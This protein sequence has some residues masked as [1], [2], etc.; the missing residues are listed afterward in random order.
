MAAQPSFVQQFYAVLRT[1]L[2]RLI[3]C[4]PFHLVTHRSQSGRSR[5]KWRSPLSSGH[6]D[7]PGHRHSRYSLLYPFLRYAQSVK[8]RDRR[9]Q[10]PAIA[11]FVLPTVTLMLIVV[12]L[13]VA[14]LVFRAYNHT[15][16]I[17]GETQ[18][19]VIYNAA[20]PA[21]DRARAK[22][23]TLFDTNRDNRYP[24]GVPAENYL[25]GMLR[26]D[27]SYNVTVLPG[28]PGNDLYTLPGET[29]V[30]LDGQTKA[31]EARG[32]DNAWA[33][34][35][36]VN[37][38]GT[39]DATVVYAIIMQTPP[40]ATVASPGG[41]PNRSIPGSGIVSTSDRTKAQNLWV[42]TAPLS[43]RQR[44][45]CG[46]IDTQTAS[47]GQGWF[48]DLGNSSTL[49]KNFQIEALVI[50]DT[51]TTRPSFVTLEM[52]HDR[53]LDRGNKWGAWFRNDL[54]VFPGA[55]FNWNGA[56]H[57]EGNL[58]IQPGGGGSFTAFLVSAQ[59]SCLMSTPG[60]SEI[61]VTNI[62]NP[63]ADPTRTPDFIGGVLSGTVGSNSYGGSS[64]IHVWPALATGPSQ[65][66]ALN[67][68]SQSANSS[69]NPA[70]MAL[71]PV[72]L[73]TRD[74]SL[75]RNGDPSNR[76]NVAPNW[77][78]LPGNSRN[79]RIINRAEPKPYVDDLYRADD[80][81]GPKP[82][83][84]DQIV[85]R[86]AGQQPGTLITS[87]NVSTSED[88]ATLVNN[89]P[90]TD[91][92]ANVGLDGYWERRALNE[93]ARIIVGQR[94]EL[95]NP[96]GWT[97]A[98][99]VNTANTDPLK[100]D[101]L[102]PPDLAPMSHSQRQRRTLRDNQAAVQAS[103]I[104][105]AAN[106]NGRNFPAACLASTSH[107]GS[108]GSLQNS[109]RFNTL[110]SGALLTDFF[111]GNGT[112][113]WEF[114]APAASETA[115]A[116]AI[117]PG[118]P[119]GKALRNLAHFAGDYVSD[120]QH[121][122]FPPTQE[123]GTVHPYPTQTM[124]GNFSE[125]RR[126]LARLDGG[127]AYI[128]LSPADKTNLHTA[129]CTLG[130][131]AY[132]VDTLQGYDLGSSA[133]A[134]NG[135]NPGLAM[136]GNKLFDLID[137][138]TNNGEVRNPATGN[139]F[140]FT[141]Q[142]Q[143]AA[144]FETQG[145][146]AYGDLPPETF[147][148]ALLTE[149][150]PG[151]SQ[152]DK[153]AL[154]ILARTVIGKQQ[155]DRDR[156]FGFKLGT[157]P[158][159]ATSSGYWASNGKT[160][161][162]QG[163]GGTDLTFPT[164]CD[165]ESFPLNNS[166]N[167]VAQARQ[168]IGL[169]LAFCESSPRY[170]ALFYVFPKE[171]H[172]HDGAATPTAINANQGNEQPTNEPYISDPY[173]KTTLNGSY[174]YE[175]VGASAND[176]ANVL[177]QPRAADFSDWV[178]P[179]SAPQN[180]TGANVS[181][182][183][184]VA[185][186]GSVRAVGFL[187]RAIFNGREMMTT[188][189]MD[190]DVGMLRSRGSVATSNQP[191]LPVSGI[192]YAFREDAVREDAIARPG[193]GTT[194]NVV[195]PSTPFDPPLTLTPEGI[196]TTTKQV[197]YLPDPDRRPHGFRLRNGAQVKR[198]D[199]FGIPVAD[200]IRGLSFFTDNPVYIQGD[201][202]L[203]QSGGD[204][205]VSPILEEFTDLL[206]ND[207][208]NFYARNQRNT[209]FARPAGDRWRPS[210]ILADAISIVSDSFCD[211]SIEDTFA[212][213]TASTYHNPAIGLWGPGCT[214]STTS[215]SNQNRPTSSPTWVRENIGDTATIK[216]SAVKIDRNGRPLTSSG[217]YDGTYLAFGQDKPLMTAQDNTRVNAIVVS[218]IVP[219]RPN[220]AYGGL[221][222]FLRFLEDWNGRWLRFNGSFLQLSFSNYATGPY[223]QDAWEPGAAPGGQELLEYYWPPNRAW[224]YDTALQLAPAGPAAAR[225][226]TA[227]QTRN[228]FYSELAVS[229]AYMNQLC[230]AFNATPKG[231]VLAGAPAT[232]PCL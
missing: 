32:E 89:T 67:T 36:D 49:R 179:N 79:P 76:A 187:E 113:G 55:A 63:T 154:A 45:N 7:R 12:V 166:N 136:L 88:F 172:D 167:P 64:N 66:A 83:Y 68:G 96:Y 18:Q 204:N 192:I 135:S 74:V 31:G 137:G 14:A 224:G 50:P 81:W 141:G 208:S 121:G 104:Y 200:N 111:T 101:P 75:A 177:L 218:G 155:I 133:N 169:A 82:R 86:G 53:Q 194:T 151:L 48:Q 206:A 60:S 16:Q 29:R 87:G 105:H 156:I 168:R 91:N 35:T 38:D 212:N 20:T 162:A 184:I 3:R 140:S 106:P 22:I 108:L 142:N 11:G 23:E 6:R 174:T 61:T 146:Q 128:N 34:R 231:G 205:A 115:F 100:L 2:K 28:A 119:L 97:P 150:I 1:L 90:P 230:T 152:S 17:I 114:A 5:R 165:P 77:Q 56:M 219:S 148:N 46:T 112:N 183:L 72:A 216:T 225:F 158:P 161:K 51:A 26:N 123:N 125:L 159:P 30:N 217:P 107:P 42:R 27:G 99:A 13:T 52:Q 171:S 226:V 24:G 10:H 103:A 120:A 195:N 191:W 145:P 163:Q 118:Q 160:Y 199:S 65:T 102:Y 193:G 201:F 211:G 185:P 62:P 157:V 138:K 221:H 41:G 122:A 196:Q 9:H 71:D 129:A 210:E 94:L 98:K 153:N 229:D 19:R 203:H 44:G 127:V 214:G 69:K 188:R 110:N 213:P 228:E 25:T 78:G 126:T 170:P 189:V 43:N 117:A 180:L 176:L 164:S 92:N 181:P 37:G 54:E 124:W 223:D 73:L 21:I 143:P 232:V 58:I 198:N 131:L 4:V 182:N 207:Y 59:N 132:S 8:H 39:D 178:L 222:N 84:T 149:N 139:Y 134:G 144:N 186:N 40:D 85:L 70:D 57:T 93:G 116:N 173:I 33:F 109:I 202:N 175:V 227:S 147:V 130:M 80:R 190:I 95:G 15:S 47:V 215:F 209:N 220:Q 197:D